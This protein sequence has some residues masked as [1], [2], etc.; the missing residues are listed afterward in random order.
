[1]RARVPSASSIANLVPGL[2]SPPTSE[3]RSSTTDAC[4][5]LLAASAVLQTGGGDCML[6]ACL[7]ES[8]A[9]AHTPPSNLGMHE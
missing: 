2:P 4:S 6:L 8:A 1:M 7:H 5:M 9:R 3:R